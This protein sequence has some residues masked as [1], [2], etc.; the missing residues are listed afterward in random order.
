M[1]GALASSDK[2]KPLMKD[3][4]SNRLFMMLL[5]IRDQGADIGLQLCA[6]THAC[7]HTHTHTL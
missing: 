6:F 7:M 4:D 5:V 3:D 2:V 1:R